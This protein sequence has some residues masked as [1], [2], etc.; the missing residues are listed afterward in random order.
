MRLDTPGAK[1]GPCDEIKATAMKYGLSPR[2]LGYLLK[3]Q[4]KLGWTKS[5]GKVKY[6]AAYVR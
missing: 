5:K 3:G 6:G 4:L 2:S 1:I